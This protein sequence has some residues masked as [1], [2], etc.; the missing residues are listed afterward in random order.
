MCIYTT[1]VVAFALVLAYV[2]NYLQKQDRVLKTEKE[3]DA[4]DSADANVGQSNV[5]FTRRD[6]EADSPSEKTVEEIEEVEGC[7]QEGK[8]RCHKTQYLDLLAFVAF[9][10]L[11]GFASSQIG[12]GADIT[13]YAYCSLIYNSR[14]GV[15][16]MSGNDLTATSVIVMAT[17]SVF[18]SVLRVSTRG[19][20]AVS[21]EA[22]HALMACA[23]IVVVGA[24][25]GSLFLSPNHQRRLKILFYVL[26]V[27]Q[28]ASFGVIKIQRNT[29][30]WLVVG[31]ILFAICVAIVLADA[32][33]FRTGMLSFASSTKQ[34][35][36][37]AVPSR[38][39]TN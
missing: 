23:C 21:A 9:N 26:A 13:W 25:C 39:S 37:A 15:P 31:G 3:E 28:L 20:D 19:T 2:E 34:F 18:G 8:S 24:P 4:G 7:Q 6:V 38:V 29:V 17:T 5:E 16:K 36:G 12:S 33:V 14:R 11:G 10:L 35:A 22:Y 27:V 30:A 32:F 1:L